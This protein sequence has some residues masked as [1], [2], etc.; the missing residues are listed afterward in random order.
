[1]G[2][3]PTTEEV[4]EETE[5]LR[6]ELDGA[7]FERGSNERA[8]RSSAER[9]MSAYALPIAEHRDALAAA[10]AKIDAIRNSIIGRQGVNW[11]A[12]IYPIVAALDEAGYGGEG[13]EVARPKAEA[14]RA[15]MAAVFADRDALAAEVVTIVRELGGEVEGLPTQTI[16]YLQ[17][18]RALR[19][20]EADRD[21]LAAE[22][23]RLREA[24][25]DCCET[26]ADTADRM[27]AERDALRPLAELGALAL[28]PNTLPALINALLRLCTHAQLGEVVVPRRAGEW[29]PEPADPNGEASRYMFGDG[30]GVGTVRLQTDGTWTAWWLDGW[31]WTYKP[32]HPTRAEAEAAV[33]ERLRAD[34]VVLP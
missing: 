1:M 18:I 20:I 23:A 10:L 6:R 27:A 25:A 5:R 33:D 7:A 12:H 30:E 2:D 19:A 21:A 31:Q 28:G 3:A 11:S 9:A 26:A 8:R 13:Y 34:G 17:R 15:A 4:R 16:N 24:L 32:G 29:V 14:E 22:V